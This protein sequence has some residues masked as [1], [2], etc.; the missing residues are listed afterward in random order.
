MAHFP[1]STALLGRRLIPSIRESFFNH[2]F[3]EQADT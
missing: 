3:R 1:C 2:G